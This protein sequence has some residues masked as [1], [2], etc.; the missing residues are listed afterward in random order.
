MRW[1]PFMIRSFDIFLNRLVSSIKRRT[2]AVA[3]IRQQPR[4]L[5]YVSDGR[6]IECCKHAWHQRNRSFTFVIM[7]AVM[8][9][10]CYGRRSIVDMLG[11]LRCLE[12]IA[13]S[14][15]DP[16]GL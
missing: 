4:R 5:R 3:A 1:H 12:V 16:S 6:Q 11:H 13:P 10:L 7:P 8:F 15:G 2:A 9:I 14:V